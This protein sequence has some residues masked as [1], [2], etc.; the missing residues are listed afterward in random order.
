MF[1]NE[2]PSNARLATLA[3]LRL[4]VLPAFLNPIPSAVTLRIWFDREKIPRFKSNPSAKRGGGPVWYS[5]PAVEKM[6]RG[7][8]LPGKIR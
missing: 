5:V 3:T 6:L 8:L 1:E 2:G 7:R 4:T